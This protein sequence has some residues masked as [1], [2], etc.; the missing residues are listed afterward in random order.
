MKTDNYRIFILLFQ[1]ILLSWYA[2]AQLY[3]WRGP[4]RSGIYN[5]SNLLKCWPDSGPELLWEYEGLGAGF[6]SVT[7]TDE[8]VYT[9]GK[10]NDDEVLTALTLQGQKKWAIIFGRPWTGSYPDSRCTPTYLNGKLFVVSG[11]GDL[12]CL[13][14]AGKILWS[15]NFP[16]LCVGANPPYGI[17]ESPLV[18]DHMVIVTPGGSTTSLAAFHIETGQ[19]IWQSEPIN[20]MAQYV[21]PKLVDHNGRKII[22]TLLEKNILAADVKNGHLLWTF[23]YADYFSKEAIGFTNHA[24]TPIYRDGYLFITSGW[25]YTALKLKLSEDD[26]S[27]QIAWESNDMDPTLGGVVLVGDYL[28]SSTFINNSRGRW[29]CLSWETGKTL[30]ST[31]WHNSG[32]VI[33]ADNMLYLYEEKSGYVGL[34]KPDPERLNV[35]SEFRITKGDG[36]HWA[37]PVIHDGRLYIRHGEVLMAYSLRDRLQK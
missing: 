37:H 11:L 6:S 26:T 13:D 35:V 32:S 27:V 36:P 20:D 15:V 12:V 25:N 5:Q 9:T 16:E 8:A 21:N 31:D 30:W 29:S 4:G 7:V 19:M 18:T 34:V 2:D 1:F 14:T 22:I 10:I 33:S 17:S 23:N 3:E 24:I 28:F